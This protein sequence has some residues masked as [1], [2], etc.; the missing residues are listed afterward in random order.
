MI[1]NLK[2]K[3]NEQRNEKNRLLNVEENLVA[4]TGEVSGRISEIDKGDEEEQ[5]SRCK[6][7]KSWRQKVQQREDSQ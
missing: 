1:R 2:N 7:S 6:I 5:I 3:I 4:A